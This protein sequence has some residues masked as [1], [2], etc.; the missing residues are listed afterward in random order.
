MSCQRSVVLVPDS[1][2]V[3]AL[4]PFESQSSPFDGTA[5]R[6][7]RPADAALVIVHLALLVIQE[8]VHLDLIK[9]EARIHPSAQIKDGTFRDPIGGDLFSQVPPLVPCSIRHEVGPQSCALVPVIPQ[10]LFKLIPQLLIRLGEPAVR[11]T[12]ALQRVVLERTSMGST[13]APRSGP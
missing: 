8:L 4:S 6:D 11:H 7:A 12:W 9:I 5:H 2:P 3:E 10:R 13:V 1:F